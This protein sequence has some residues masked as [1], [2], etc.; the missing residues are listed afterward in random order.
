MMKFLTFNLVVAAALGYLLLADRPDIQSDGVAAKLVESAE[1]TWDKARQSIE[2]GSEILT[3]QVAPDPTPTPQFVPELP[4]VV[5]PRE[6]PKAVETAVPEA[7]APAAVE[8]AAISDDQ[9]KANRIAKKDPAV[10]GRRAEVLADGKV[11][12]DEVATSGFMSARQRR[13]ELLRLAEDMELQFLD[14]VRQ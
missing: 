2:A 4:V 10:A 3:G 7:P 9:I 1:K 14:T 12:R 6:S 13:T 8:I 11:T 5:P